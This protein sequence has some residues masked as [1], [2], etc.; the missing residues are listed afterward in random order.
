MGRKPIPLQNRRDS[1]YMLMLTARELEA[2]EAE[3]VRLGFRSTAEYIRDR[4]IPAGAVRPMDKAGDD[5]GA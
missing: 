2:V 5:S 3:A 4:I 1:R